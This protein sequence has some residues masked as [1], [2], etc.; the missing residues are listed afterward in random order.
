MPGPAPKPTKLKQILGNPG[1]RALNKSEPVSPQL[2]P[3][4]PEWLDETALEFWS[5]VVAIVGPMGHVQQ[6]DRHLVMLL[7]LELSQLRQAHEDMRKFG[8]TVVYENGVEQV[9]P[10]V[11]IANKATKNAIQILAQLGMT[12]SARSRIVV[13][14]AKEEDPFDSFLKQKRA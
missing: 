3:V 11:T 10:Y 9:S 13:N 4:P 12:P 6:S 5:E 8:R 2:D 1:R 14:A 7:A